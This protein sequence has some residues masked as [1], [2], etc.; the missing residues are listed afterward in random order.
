VSGF[1]YAQLAALAVDALALKQQ[2]AAAPAP[3]IF[4]DV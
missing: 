4:V 1:G 3:E 2:L